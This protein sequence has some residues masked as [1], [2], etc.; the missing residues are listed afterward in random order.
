VPRRGGGDPKEG[1]GSKGNSRHILSPLSAVT[2]A[3]VPA[4]CR[5]R[6]FSLTTGSPLA[7]SREGGREVFF[8]WA[9][10]NPS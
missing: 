1:G 5:T 4:V 2:P 10:Q 7:C 6:Y 8:F 9:K 3:P